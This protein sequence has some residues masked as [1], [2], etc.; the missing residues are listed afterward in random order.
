MD[1]NLLL[2]SFRFE[3]EIQVEFLIAACI[4]T[5]PHIIVIDWDLRSK[6]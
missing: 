5:E 2:D 4:S 1:F 6:S 3:A